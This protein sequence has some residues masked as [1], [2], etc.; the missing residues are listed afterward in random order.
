MILHLL[1]I[2]YSAEVDL[3]IDDFAEI[4]ARIPLAGRCQTLR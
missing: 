3:S 1:A 4:G 2:A